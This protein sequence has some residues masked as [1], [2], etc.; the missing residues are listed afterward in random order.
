VGIISK[1]VVF[2]KNKRGFDASQLGGHELLQLLRSHEVVEFSLLL[3]H[4]SQGWVWD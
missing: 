1:T 3:L 4:Q 2:I